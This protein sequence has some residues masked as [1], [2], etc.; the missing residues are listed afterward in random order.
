MPIVLLLFGLLASAADAAAQQTAAAPQPPVAATL[1]PPPAG[2]GPPPPELPDTISRDDQGR[3]T[4]RAVRVTTPMRVDGKLDEAVYESIRPASN[5]IQMEPRAGQEATERTE[6]WLFYDNNNLYVSFKA[7]ES[8]PERMVANELRRDSGNIRQGD[9][10]GFGFDTFRDRRNALQFETNPLGARSDGQSTNER[11]F[12]AD[13]N[14]VW[15]V[16]AGKFD[17]GWTIEAY[18]PFKSIRYAPGTQ[19]VWGFQARRI[20]KWKNEISYLTRV[21]N[22][23]GLGRADFS[24]SLYSTLVGLEVPNLSRTLE[25]KPFAI[26]DLTTDNV[27]NPRRANDPSA[28][29]G[30]DAKYAITQN[31]TAD[32][33]VNT[34]FAQVEADEQQV[35]LTRFT[36]FFPEKRDFF[37][38]NQGIFTFGNNQGPGSTGNAS[39]VPIPF[40]SRRIGLAQGRTGQVNV[41]ILAGGRVTGRIGRYQLGMVN[42][43]TREDQAVGAQ[44][45]NFSVLRVRRDFLRRSSIGAMATSR[46]ESQVGPGSNQFYGVDG[47]FAFFNNLLFTTYWA[48]TRSEGVDALNTSYRAQVDYAGDRYGVQLER[49]SVD[50]NFNPEVGFLRRTDMRKNFASFRFSP[51]PRRNRIIRKYYYVGALTYIEDSAGRVSTRLQDGSFDIEF[52]SSDRLSVGYLDD[53]ELLLRPFTVGGVQ[54]PAGG[55]QFGTARAAYF[56]GQQRP[57]SGSIGVEVGDF[58]NGKRTALAFNRSRVNLSPV[59]SLEPSVAI[60]WIDLPTGQVTTK[61]FSS[62][63]TYTMTPL[64]F[65]SAL[66]QYNSTTRLV[67]VNARLRWEY[68]L[69]SELFIVYNEDRDRGAAVGLPGLQNRAFIVKVNRFFRF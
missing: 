39:D 6:V 30:I 5:F 67:S 54:I 23:F 63:I 12:N 50:P 11:Q 45:S 44:A 69:G 53:Y 36:L 59:F 16:V 15:R 8:Q 20:S 60:N 68:R 37:L 57:M 41:P 9:S 46:S 2:Q 27:S 47:N 19:Q 26:S 61:L 29:A 38:E 49:L 58:Y 42:M 14:P 7:Y 10:V 51:R 55:Y 13:W 33:T 21:P 24:A 62:R 1:P 35:N 31:M 56:L 28:D 43:Q 25:L 32:F 52:Q 18:I 48:Q 3:A 17:G 65:A 22:A 66:V 40:Y 34:D 64:M 4:V